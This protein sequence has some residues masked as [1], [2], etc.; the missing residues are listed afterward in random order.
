MEKLINSL[1]LVMKMI[2][3]IIFLSAN[4]LLSLIFLFL[5]FL[6]DN[7]ILGLFL[8]LLIQ[9]TGYILYKES[10]KMFKNIDS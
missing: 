5:I 4:L 8:I 9:F 1:N 6:F 3:G 2:I 10:I 7:I